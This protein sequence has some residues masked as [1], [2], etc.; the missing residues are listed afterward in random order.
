M[1]WISVDK[2]LPDYQ[3]SVLVWYGH[4]ARIGIERRSH[5]DKT[6]EH[7]TGEYE[8]WITHWMPLPEPPAQEV[9]K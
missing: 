5:T 7:F 3:V 1:K 6:G 4:T 2:G 9:G 8:Y